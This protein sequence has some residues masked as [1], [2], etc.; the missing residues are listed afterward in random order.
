M[1]LFDE[2]EPSRCALIPTLAVALVPTLSQDKLSED[3]IDLDIN[4]QATENNNLELNNKQ[5]SEGGKRNSYLEKAHKSDS[6]I[7]KFN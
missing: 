6:A 3:L 1:T 4:F 7:L 2:N 5:N